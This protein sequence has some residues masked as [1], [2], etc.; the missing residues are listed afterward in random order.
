MNY[1]ECPIMRTLEVIGGKWKPIILHFLAQEP[2]RAGELTR[3]VPQA[4]GK[5]L[6]EQLREL[7]RDGIVTRTIHS[8]VPPRV[9]YALSDLGRTLLPVLDSMCLW[10]KQHPA[11]SR[12]AGVGMEVALGV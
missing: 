12:L 8:Q 4:S 2:R 1:N 11:K 9:D 3:L 10:G 7:E 5:V 6:T